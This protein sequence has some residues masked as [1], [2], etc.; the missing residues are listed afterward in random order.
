MR[1]ISAKLYRSAPVGKEAS[2]R[3]L[4]GEW[5]SSLGDSQSVLATSR[6]DSLRAL[7]RKSSSTCAALAGF[8][9]RGGRTSAGL[10][11]KRVG[12]TKGSAFDR[13]QYSSSP[14]STIFAHEAAGSAA[15][16][17]GSTDFWS[18]ASVAVDSKAGTTRIILVGVVPVDSSHLSEQQ[19]CPMAAA[20]PP[21]MF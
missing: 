5:H 17:P 13:L 12:K 21:A 20:A 6:D 7:V 1:I 9:G 11:R 3:P 18:L 14:A 2:S 16:E 19:H 15:A 8:L 4:G 10:R